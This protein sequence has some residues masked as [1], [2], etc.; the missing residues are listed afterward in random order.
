MF[1]HTHWFLDS[2]SWSTCCT[3]TVDF[4]NSSHLSDFLLVVPLPPFKCWCSSEQWLLPFSL[5]VFRPSAPYC[6]FS[7]HV[8]VVRSSKWPA[9]L[10]HSPDCRVSW[11]RVPTR[12]A[13][14]MAFSRLRP[15]L[16]GSSCLHSL[17]SS[18]VYW[19]IQARN[20]LCASQQQARSGP[21]HG[22]HPASAFILAV[23]SKW[24]LP[25]SFFQT[26]HPPCCQ[27]NSKFKSDHVL[28]HKF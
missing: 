8:F 14:W 3:H 21:E 16:S 22:H 19:A 4:K 9:Y 18:S 6:G 1:C 12:N 5:G 24:P 7:Y 13:I 28:L 2:L 23:V 26:C 27:R 20:A 17:F 10:D 25:G 11:S 15:R